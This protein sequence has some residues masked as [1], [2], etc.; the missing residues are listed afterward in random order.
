MGKP[1]AVT[2]Y[3]LKI[4][5][6]YLL[7]SFLWIVFSD[8]FVEGIAIDKVALST[9]QTYKGW[10]FI[11]MSALLVFAI[12]LR[13]LKELQQAGQS[14]KQ[15]QEVLSET[16]RVMATLY[17]NLPGF[18]YRRQ[19]DRDWHM[20]FVSDGCFD[21]V[22]Y[23]RHE[24]MGGEV[25]SY[26]DLIVDGDRQRVGDA[27]E[28]AVADGSTYQVEYRV[29]HRDGSVRW[30]WEQGCG[31]YGERG[32]LLALEGF[33]TDISEKKRLQEQLQVSARLEHI[34]QAAST[35][36]H[37]LKNQMQVILGNVELLRLQPIPPKSSRH[38]DV[39][40]NQVEVMLSCSREMLDYARGENSLKFTPVDTRALLRLLVDTYGP[41][42][43][44]HSIDLTLELREE[45]D[46][47][48]MFDLDHDRI[49]RALINLIV[50]ARDALKNG[51]EIA[52]RAHVERHKITI[53]IQDNGPGIPEEIQ[54]R[55]FDAFVTHGKT[56]G[57][58]L[59]LAIVRKIVESHGGS[60]G[61]HSAL[62]AGT[63]F[64]VVLPRLGMAAPQRLQEVSE[65]VPAAT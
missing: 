7:V 51:G 1:N 8:R 35:I 32:A 16:Q 62:G 9:M 13:Y 48:V 5:I 3:A 34:G 49:A 11:T 40:E 25:S 15:S 59:G 50:N 29:R 19:L 17:A 6:P 12:S 21:T 63:T 27:I 60:I 44:K 55:L 20:Q 18:A 33:I 2:G 23:T 10:F 39:I 64:V 31:V 65:S 58:G 37:D 42:F 57:T 30:V 56:G 46:V 38:L 14:L 45:S 61:Y 41:E 36:I 26:A 52:L 24:L 53:E 28:A 22:G 54:G 47:S 43:A 4:T